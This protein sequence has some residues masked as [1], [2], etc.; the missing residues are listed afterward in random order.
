MKKGTGVY[1]Y[2]VVYKDEMFKE[3]AEKLIDL[4]RSAQKHCP[5]QPRLLFLDIDNHKNELGKFDHDMYDLQFFC[6]GALL[7]YLTELHMPLF[8]RNGEALRNPKEQCTDIPEGLVIK[9]VT[10]AELDKLQGKKIGDN[11]K[12]CSLQELSRGKYG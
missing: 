11:I 10:R 4:I 7:K 3:S 2:H 12:E 8:T 6:M 1:I 9:E 5:G